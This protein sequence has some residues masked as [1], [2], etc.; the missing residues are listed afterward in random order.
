MAKLSSAD[1]SILLTPLMPE[2]DLFDRVDHLALD[3][4]G[5]RAGIDDR[6]RDDGRLDVRE[7]VGLELDQREDAEHHERQHR[8]D[9]DDRPADGEIGDEH[10]YWFDPLTGVCPA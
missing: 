6:D 1:E 9:G 7:L 8:D 5:R 4:V 10:D 2:I 3:V